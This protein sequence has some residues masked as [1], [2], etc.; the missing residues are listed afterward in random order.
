MTGTIRAGSYRRLLSEP[1]TRRTYL[2]SSLGR[3]G[4]AMLPLLFL[5]TVRQATGSFALA[6]TAMSVV[7]L[8]AL[9]MPAKS[10]L[11]DRYGQR[12]VLIPLALGSLVALAGAGALGAAGVASP[13]IWLAI[14]ALEGLLAPPLGPAMR[15][16]W[17]VLAQGTIRSAYALDAV[18]EEALW[19]AGPALAGLLLALG[20]ARSGLLVVPVLILIGALGLAF[21]PAQSARPDRPLGRTRRGVITQRA[22][23]RVLAFMAAFGAAGALLFTGVAARA[24]ATGRPA[25]AA[26]AETAI[27]VGAVLGGL[28]WGRARVTVSRSA[29]AA[30]LLGGWTALVGLSAALDL[31]GWALG[32]LLLAGAAGSPLWVIAYEAADDAVRP[33]ERTEASTW[34]TTAANLGGSAGTALAGVLTAGVRP[35]APIL[36]AAALGSVVAAA[37][38][39]AVAMTG[40]TGWRPVRR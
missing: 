1:A 9:S 33:G 27:G 20:P 4:Y 17:R 32:A 22:L 10:R 25:L 23:W 38:C 28:A 6:A 7:A 36:A 11:I 8:T 19:L 5:F 31:A 12:A 2:L 34:V 14:A 16:Q 35:T 39:I 26:V 37:A 30:F 40:R 24:D 29:S 3:G 21:S 15:A 13:S 18:T